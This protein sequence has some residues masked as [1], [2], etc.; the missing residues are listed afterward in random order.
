[1]KYVYILWGSDSE[2][3]WIEAIFADKVKAESAMRYLKETDN[4]RG[5]IYWVQEKTVS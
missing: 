3:P 5:Y 2:N 4:G 1:M